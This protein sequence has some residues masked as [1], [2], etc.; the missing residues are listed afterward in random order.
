MIAASR[1]SQVHSSIITLAPTLSV[2]I[3]RR[4]STEP[5]KEE[6]DLPTP[7]PNSATERTDA[8]ANGERE[9]KSRNGGSGGSG[10]SGANG[11]IND[12]AKILEEEMKQCK[13]DLDAKVKEATEFKVSFQLGIGN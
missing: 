8:S 2:P 11:G 9:G 12:A 6:R 5:Q 4:Y 3:W 10:A 1:P 13:L 7:T